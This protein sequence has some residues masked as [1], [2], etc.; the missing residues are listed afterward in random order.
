MKNFKAVFLIFAAALLI[1]AG[2]NFP[3]AG[4][5]SAES[6]KLNPARGQDNLRV[7]F[8][9]VGQG[10]AALIQTPGGQKILVDGG[11]DS[12]ILDKLGGAL[13]FGDRYLD[14]IILTH[15][16]SDHLAGLLPVIRRYRVGEIYYTGF[17]HNTAE[18][19]EWQ[20]LIAEKNITLK[21]I[22]EPRNINYGQVKLEMIYPD[23]D[24]SQ[25]RFAAGERDDRVEGKEIN[26]TSIVFRL[27]FGKSKFLFLGDAETE[28]EEELLRSGAD[29]DAQVLKVGHHGSHSSTSNALLEECSPD[30]AVISVGQDNDYGH[31]H[32]RTL[33]RLERHGVDILRTDLDGDIQFVSDGE[34]VYYRK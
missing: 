31:P 8:F 12:A 16:H 20:R 26:N 33:R 19:R 17:E 21:I 27:V 32:R 22:K 10:D 1:W 3:A 34:R 25:S 18:F 30:Y 9:D 15:P 29:L 28:V 11:P 14:A 4:L 2:Q 7:T 6:E 5:K 24:L 13:P 23:E